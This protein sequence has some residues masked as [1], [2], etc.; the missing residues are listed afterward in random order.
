MTIAINRINAKELVTVRFREEGSA[1]TYETAM[2]I[3]LDYRN[4]PEIRNQDLLID[5]KYFQSALQKLKQYKNFE[6]TFDIAE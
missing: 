2:D 4:F 3:P 6:I 5:L 1:N